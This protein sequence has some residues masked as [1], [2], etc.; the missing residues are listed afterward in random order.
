MGT[1]STLSTDGRRV[2]MFDVTDRATKAT[3]LA[4]V[5][6]WRGG[7]SSVLREPLWHALLRVFRRRHRRTH[8][9][10]RFPSLPEGFNGGASLGDPREVLYSEKLGIVRLLGRDFPVP[11]DGRTLLLLVDEPSEGPAAST[12]TS[13]ALDVAPQAPFPAIDR[14]L[15]REEMARRI[16]DHQRGVNAAW[17]EVVDSDPRVRSFLDARR[18]VPTTSSE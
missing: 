14:S 5:V 7:A 13:H 4:A 6:V 18:R 10:D 2:V 9:P 3:R 12:V 1:T 11:S 8:V 15:S 17:H 16:G